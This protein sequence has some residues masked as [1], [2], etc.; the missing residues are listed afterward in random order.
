MPGVG[1]HEW[2]ELRAAIPVAIMNEESASIVGMIVF[3]F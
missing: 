2:Q 3:D 1:A